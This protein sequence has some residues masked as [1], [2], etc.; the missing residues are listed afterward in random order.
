MN[1]LRKPHCNC[2]QTFIINNEQMWVHMSAPIFCKK[3][4]KKPE[5]TD[6]LRYLTLIDNWETSGK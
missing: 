1:I 3:K 5:M 4:P 6:R 2:R